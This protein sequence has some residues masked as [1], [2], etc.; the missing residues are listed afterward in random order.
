MPATPRQKKGGASHGS[1]ALSYRRAYA[2]V[3]KTL[4]PLPRAK[5]RFAGKRVPE[6]RRACRFDM[7]KA[8]S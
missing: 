2:V 1:P 5:Q 6:E 3:S 7:L 4:F 8:L